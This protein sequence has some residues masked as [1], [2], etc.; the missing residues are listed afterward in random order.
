VTSKERFNK[1]M[2]YQGYDR[3]P[4]KYYG[5]PEVTRA[6]LDHFSLGDE[7]SLL[8]KLGD[9]FREVGLRYI[10]PELGKY[11]DGSWEEIWG[12]HRMNI[13]FQGGV[14][15]EMVYLPFKDV[16]DVAELDKHRFPS[17]DWY[18]YSNIKDNCQRL[19]DYVIYA[20]GSHHPDF[21]NGIGRC[22]GVEQTLLDVAMEHPVFLALVTKR[23]EFYYQLCKR[24]LEAAD[25]L[26]DV[27]CFGEDLGS[28]KGPTISPQSYDKLFAPYMKRLFDLAHQ[29]GART[30]MHCCGSCRKFIPRLIELGLDILEVVQVDT[31]DMDIEGL[32]GAFYKKIAFCGS[33]SVQDTL[34]FGTVED[35]IREVELRKVLFKEGG[36]VIAPTHN[37]QVG[38]PVDNILALYEAVGSLQ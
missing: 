21:L 19:E 32:H 35:V 23:F 24:M 5:T 36:M 7:E 33:I 28:Q 4:T 31:A 29:Y 11:E 27:Y 26:I 16:D 3:P 1:A 34:P 38:T 2:T 8:T 18:D 20:G 14:Y 9:D 25:G 37:I 6:L 13:S 10:G 12:E 22:R 30:M 17:P 15:P